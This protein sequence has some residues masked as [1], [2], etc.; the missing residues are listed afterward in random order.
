[1]QGAWAQS[2]GGTKI[3]HAAQC[4]QN[5][6]INKAGTN[7]PETY[8]GSLLMKQYT[9]LAAYNHVSYTTSQTGSQ[10]SSQGEFLSEGSIEK[11]AS[12]LI[13]LFLINIFF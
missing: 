10:G 7:L 3:P 12:K 8:L 4:S 6:K 9:N 11:P 5:K 13:F 2:G 1:M